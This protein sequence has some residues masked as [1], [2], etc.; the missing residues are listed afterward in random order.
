AMQSAYQL[1]KMGGTIYVAA[2]VTVSL[3]RELGPVLTALVVAGRVGAAITA[4]LGSMKVTE[5]IEAL[6]TMAIDPV[7]FLV[8]PRFLS[9]V[10]MLPILTAYADMIGSFGGYV[11]G[12]FSL[13]LNP[14]LYVDTA[15]RFL[16]L[17]DIY[18]GLFKSAVFAVII[19]MVSCYQGLTASGGAEG[20]GK[21]TTVSVV[22]S[23][24]LVIFADCVVTGI[25]YFG[26]M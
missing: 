12:V 11:V 7:K 9:L 16:E 26:N 10:I 13:K 14:G 17:K 19:A 6:D 8:V 4:Q 24:I 22:T 2:L 20:V 15:V 21:A 23:F 18:T 1:S 25:F 5:Q 3:A